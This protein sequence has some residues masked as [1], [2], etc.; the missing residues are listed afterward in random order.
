MAVHQHQDAAGVISGEP[1]TAYAYGLVGPVVGRVKT[2]NGRERLS[3]RAIAI[4]VDLVG[5]QDGDAG[6][7]VL[8][9]LRMQGGTPHLYLQEVFQRE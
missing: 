3:Q 8:Q 9:R 5:R 2:A 1:E 4:A 7:S 6:W